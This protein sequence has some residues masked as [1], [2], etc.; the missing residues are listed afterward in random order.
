MW[1][2]VINTNEV[3]IDFKFELSW[4]AQ[5]NTSLFV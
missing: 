5:A 2:D 1:V 4:R 3:K